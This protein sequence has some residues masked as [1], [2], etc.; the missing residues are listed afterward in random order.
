[1]KMINPKNTL[2][3]LSLLGMSAFADIVN[4]YEAD[5]YKVAAKGDV[6]SLKANQSPSLKWIALTGNLTLKVPQIE[7]VSQKVIDK[8]VS[9][10]GYFSE[11]NDSYLEI[12]VP[13]S[14]F[15][16]L[17]NEFSGYG[18]TV[19][20]DFQSQDLRQKLFEAENTL[21]SRRSLLKDYFEILENSKSA[22]FIQV[23]VEVQNLLDDIEILESQLISIKERST[24]AKLRINFRFQDR[25]TPKNNSQS[26]FAWINKMNLSDLMEDFK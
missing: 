25:S 16:T 13:S 4:T 19:S 14:E 6:D 9:R 20:K 1:M 7:Q 11:R 12:K 22:T 3:V 8:A 15:K 2:I 10:G 24:W 18:V 26:E 23:E 5:S 21:K 17:L